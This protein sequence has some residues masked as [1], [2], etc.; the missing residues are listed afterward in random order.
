MRDKIDRV[1]GGQGLEV[2]K[3]DMHTHSV[4]Y[5]DISELPDK[6]KHYPVVCQRHYLVTFNNN[7]RRW[8]SVPLAMKAAWSALLRKDEELKAE[9]RKRGTKADPADIAREIIDKSTPLRPQIVV[10]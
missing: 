7:L 3:F 1:T 4:Y 2:A 8:H 5:S 10:A 9:Q 6:V